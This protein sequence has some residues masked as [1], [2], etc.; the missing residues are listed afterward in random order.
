[1]PEHCH[2][3][4]FGW[5]PCLKMVHIAVK[6]LADRQLACWVRVLKFV[7]RRCVLDSEIFDD[8][9]GRSSPQGRKQQPTVKVCQNDGNQKAA[10]G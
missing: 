5:R 2:N 6:I 1:M 8:E 10:A 4:H 9:N 3:K 7:V